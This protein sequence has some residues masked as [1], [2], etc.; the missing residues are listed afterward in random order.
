ML[1]G[2]N[3]TARMLFDSILPAWLDEGTA[4]DDVNQDEPPTAPA[5]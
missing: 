4:P 2:L 5:V 3:L 1:P